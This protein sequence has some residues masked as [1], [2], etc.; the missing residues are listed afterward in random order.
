MAT[1]IGVT[2][3]LYAAIF[4][5]AGVGWGRWWTERQIRQDAAATQKGRMQ[6]TMPV[7]PEDAAAILHLL[8][9]LVEQAETDRKA[10]AMKTP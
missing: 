10:R 6:V 8:A 1:G 9:S 5:C 2:L 4:F 7:T 3:V